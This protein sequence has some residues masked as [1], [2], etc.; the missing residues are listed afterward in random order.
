MVALPPNAALRS[1]IHFTVLGILGESPW[2]LTEQCF[3]QDWEAASIG[4][5]L[6]IAASYGQ[7]FAE[8]VVQCADA[9]RGDWPLCG[10]VNHRAATRYVVAVAD[11]SRD[12][13]PGGCGAPLAMLPLDD[14][15]SRV[16][17]HPSALARRLPDT[18]AVLFA[19]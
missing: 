6:S 7:T 8:C 11:I 12:S 17:R 16:L 18:A 10:V 5:S 9:R 2:L 1:R 14:A 13:Y 19:M 15:A 4:P 3:I